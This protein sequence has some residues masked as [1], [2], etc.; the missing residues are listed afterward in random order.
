ML[1]K[2]TKL[3]NLLWTGSG[4]QELLE[5]HV[6]STEHENQSQSA[7]KIYTKMLKGKGCGRGE[8][9]R[10]EGE[11]TFG[12]TDHEMVSGSLYGKGT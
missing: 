3:A 10:R 9:S 2:R 7:Q 11:S 5:V 12:I 1:R 8:R 4:Y 6:R